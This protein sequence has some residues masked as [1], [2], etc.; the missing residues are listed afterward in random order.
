[1]AKIVIEGTDA[2]I[3]KLT[4]LATGFRC[5]VEPYFEALPETMDEQPVA[6]EEIADEQ[7]VPVK[8]VKTKKAK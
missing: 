8:E 5:V 1:M 2:A 7:P 3:E 6:V 4:R